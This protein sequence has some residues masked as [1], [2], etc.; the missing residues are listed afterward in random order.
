MNDFHVS[1]PLKAYDQS[2][3][4]DC[5][6]SYKNRSVSEIGPMYVDVIAK[7]VSTPGK[8]EI[9]N[10][11][12]KET[13]FLYID[14]NCPLM[15]YDWFTSPLALPDSV[16]KKCK[17]NML[18]HIMNAAKEAERVQVKHFK[19]S[20]SEFGQQKTYYCSGA[21]D[22]KD[23]VVNFEHIN[24]NYK[25]K[26]FLNLLNFCVVN[27]IAFEKPIT[28]YCSSVKKNDAIYAFNIQ[29]EGLNGAI[30]Y[31]SRTLNLLGISEKLEYSQSFSFEGKQYLV[32]VLKHLLPEMEYSNTFSIKVYCITSETEIEHIIHN[33]CF[34]VINYQRYIK[35]RLTEIV[36]NFEYLL[37]HD[38]ELSNHKSFILKLYKSII[39]N[40]E[41][42]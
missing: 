25:L 30:A 23:Q 37:I 10:F 21:I 26:M 20:R 9:V 32:S 33:E 5:S 2:L 3:I 27:N 13:A 7:G 36:N 38:G 31:I 22:S 16:Y 28:M 41:Q 35:F 1:L 4:I 15:E 6:N 8:I 17:D 39:T 34:D 11:P 14:K 40:H 18:L 24:H 29:P 42:N 19:I 12:L